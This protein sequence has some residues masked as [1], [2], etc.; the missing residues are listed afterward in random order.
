MDSRRP[1]GSCFGRWAALVAALVA[2]C[3]HGAGQP[4][5][6]A[7]SGAGDRAAARQ[8]A[9][10]GERWLELETPHF[11]VHTDAYPERATELAQKLEHS[12]SM[13]LAAAWPMARDPG[14]RT[15][16]VIF[17]RPSDFNRYSGRGGMVVGIS[18]T[19]RGVE[20]TIAFSPGPEGGIPSVVTHELVHDLSQWFFP[21][22]PAWFAEG[23]AVY[24]ENTRY[25][26]SS[27]EVVMGEASEYSL[28]WMTGL[29][30]FAS[31]E[32]L[33]GATS[34]H[35]DDWRD[36]TT[37]YAGAWFLVTY[38]MNGETEGFGQFQKRLHQLVPW[39]RA[40]NES[41]DG[42]TP[43]ELNQKLMGY[44]RSGGKFTIV[45]T[46]HELPVV[47]PRVR[48]LSAA[49]AHGV[50][51]S[52]ASGLAP[53]VAE[54]EAQAALALDPGELR[55]LSAQFR[56]AEDDPWARQGIAERAVAAHPRAGEAW[57][58]KAQANADESARRSAL[59]QAVAFA[60]KHPGVALLVAQAALKRGDAPR[61]LEQVRF[62]LQR[63]ALSPQ[64]LGLYAA[65]LEANGRCSEAASIAENASG[66]FAANC[67][68][69]NLGTNEPV[70]CAA[71]VQ[72]RVGSPLARCKRPKG[73]K[74]PTARVSAK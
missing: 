5:A 46:P 54:Q 58:M 57:L 11:M 62:A 56:A 49:E 36:V 45:N 25:D 33:L 30:F 43:A 34:P 60:P 9:A 42:M 4:L 55:A 41:F 7:G 48:A 19:R 35:S 20:R 22:Q 44:A 27:H 59:E 10:S 66:L 50:K 74:A 29:R 71:Y 53:E 31:A 40:W 32:R 52:L 73:P 16:A 2:G 69:Q 67:F 8:A 23:L 28:S 15:H 1:S 51:A 39:Q 18:V 13:L 37:F 38:L 63:S 3:A 6:A 26:G 72:G 61:A 68:M 47:E 12:R 14:G 24:L 17:S 65:A 64:M 70:S 21:L